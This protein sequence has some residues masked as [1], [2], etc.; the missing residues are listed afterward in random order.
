MWMAS[1]GENR[2]YVHKKCVLYICEFNYFCF[3]QPLQVN[4]FR[5]Y[6]SIFELWHEIC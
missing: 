2:F 6:D 3:H 4:A 5:F 1:Y